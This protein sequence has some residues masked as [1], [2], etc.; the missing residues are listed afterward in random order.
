MSYPAAKYGIQV[1]GKHLRN[2]IMPENRKK[3]N[4]RISVTETKA[5]IYEI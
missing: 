1:F 5:H 4:D 2:L 3:V